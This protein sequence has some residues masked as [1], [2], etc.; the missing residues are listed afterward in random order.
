MSE[1]K[2]YEL[3][4]AVPIIRMFRARAR[5]GCE[6]A[7]A[8]RLATSSI[9]VVQ[10]QPGF[11][12]YLI[13]GP[14]RDHQ[15][16]FIFVSVWANAD[17]IKARFGHEWRVSHLPPGYAELIEECSIDHYQLTGQSLACR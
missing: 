1:H 6:S 2:S 15:R 12:G 5:Q 10:H 9:G 14:A 3:R 4:P 17:A 7:L 11:L 13:A 16:E 8:E